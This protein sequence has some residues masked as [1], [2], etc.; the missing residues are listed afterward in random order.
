MLHYFVNWNSLKKLPKGV[1][2][3]PEHFKSKQII[4]LCGRR[5][6]QRHR[7]PAWPPLLHPPVAMQLRQRRRLWSAKRQSWIHEWHN[8]FSDES[9]SS[10]SI[11]MDAPVSGSS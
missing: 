8:V 10:C 2:T 6:L 3:M 11:I 4:L 7:L 1:S 9:R 5:R